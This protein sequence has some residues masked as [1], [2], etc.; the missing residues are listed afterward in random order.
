MVNKVDGNQS[1]DYVKP[2][3]LDIPDAGEKFSLGGHG[4][5]APAGLKEG[6]EEGVSGKD[7]RQTAER[8]GVRLDISSGGWSA[9]T[10]GTAGSGSSRRTETAKSGGAAGQTALLETVQAFLAKTVAAVRAFFHTLWND[11]Q[12]ETGLRESAGNEETAEGG[13]AAEGE[14][15]A[16][17]AGITEGEKSAE[18]A[19]ILEAAGTVETAGIAEETG[20]AEITEYI[21]TAETVSAAGDAE[22]TGRAAASL[23]EEYLDRE[24]RQH[25]RKGNI[26]QAIKI[27]TDNGRKTVARNSTL[28]TSYDRNGKVVEPNASVRERMLH[29]DRNIR[30]L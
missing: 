20:I 13:E 8:D 28:L 24:I 25:L 29:G 26:E 23:R 1:Y 16:G 14:E 11:P 12:A 10:S 9:G 3:K 21:G 27:L 6:K 30:K 5:G 15:S 2:K 19:G 4:G 17:T 22:R 18:T 7:K